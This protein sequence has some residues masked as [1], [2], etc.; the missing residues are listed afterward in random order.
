MLRFHLDENVDV[1]I[2]TGLRLRGGD[3]TITD[4]LG[5]KGAKDEEQIAF[6][7]RELR[8]IITH[9][10]DLLALHAQ[11]IPHA[12]IAYSAVRGRTIGQIILRLVALSRRFD[13]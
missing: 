6:A 4:E 5:M 13:P 8:V 7:L 12:G 10:D 11:G 9:D 3:V 1:A 2:G